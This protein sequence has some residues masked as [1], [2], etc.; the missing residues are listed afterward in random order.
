LNKEDLAHKLANEVFKLYTTQE[1]ES[2]YNLYG[3]KL[4]AKI[5]NEI[6]EE[7]NIP[8]E[9]FEPVIFTGESE[10]PD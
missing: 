6:A 9:N 3:G 10:I 1:L 2:K 8:G 4:V 7:L 5:Y